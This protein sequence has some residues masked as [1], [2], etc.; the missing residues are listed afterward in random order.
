MNAISAMKVFI[1]NLT[2]IG[3]SQTLLKLLKIISEIQFCNQTQKLV[4]TYF[5]NLKIYIWN[6]FIVKYQTKE[7]F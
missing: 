7:N 5:K 6:L 4:N 2:I 1:S 3:K